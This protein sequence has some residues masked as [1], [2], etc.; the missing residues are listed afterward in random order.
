MTNNSTATAENTSSNH[1]HHTTPSDSSTP[2]A[3][4]R[5][6]SKDGPN[7]DKVLVVENGVSHSSDDHTPLQNHAHFNKGELELFKDLHRSNGV[8]V[9][10]TDYD[11]DLS[12]LDSEVEEKVI[13]NSPDNRFLK[14]D[15]EIGRG[16]FKT[17]YKG[18]DTE[19]GVPVAWCELMV[20]VA[21]LR[22]FTCTTCMSII[23]C[24]Y[25]YMQVFSKNI[26]VAVTII[27]MNYEEP[28][29]TQ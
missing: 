27:I 8:G 20:G 25:M 7:E 15:L 24:I 14:Y 1:D 18:V 12:A 10:F 17:V 16:S 23:T 29:Y 9:A 11:L 3:Q 5:P 26:F 13:G 21:S 4:T 6:P 22:A 28:C 19:T 2:P